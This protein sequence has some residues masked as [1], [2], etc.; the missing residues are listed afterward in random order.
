MKNP[1]GKNGFVFVI[2]NQTAV[3]FWESRISYIS[4]CSL[5]II[6]IKNK[7]I[8]TTTME[9]S[10]LPTNVTPMNYDLKLTPSFETFTFEGHQSVDIIVSFIF[11][12]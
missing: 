7:F 10:R 8:Q 5:I 1:Y 6:Y 12:S 9:F 11:S 2:I 3:R 4:K